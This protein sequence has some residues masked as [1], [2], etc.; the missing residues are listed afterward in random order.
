MQEVI[1]FLTVLLVAVG[2]AGGI[3][4]MY[5]SGLRL[6]A[7]STVAEQEGDGYLGSR[8]ASVACFVACVIVVL[9]ALWLMIPLFH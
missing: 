3:G 8:V 7:R 6:W 4:T 5:A 2:I 9:F 1:N